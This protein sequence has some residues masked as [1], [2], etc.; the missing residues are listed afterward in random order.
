SPAAT[1][2][3]AADGDTGR[4]PVIAVAALATV[5]I[6]A[7]QNNIDMDVS[8]R[9]RRRVMR[10]RRAFEKAA[11]TGIS[12]AHSKV[13]AP[14]RTTITTPAKPTTM[15]IQRAGP[16][17]SASIGAEKAAIRV[18]LATMMVMTAASGSRL[19]A[20][21]RT[22]APTT[23]SAPRVSCPDHETIRKARQP[24]MSI[25]YGTMNSSVA[26]CRRQITCPTGNDSVKNLE[27]AS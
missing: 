10:S 16:T 18:G 11:A 7:D 13:V 21:T 25:T 19:N 4:H 17:R 15:A 26:A 14:G 24:L 3:A 22:A 20:L 2:H 23:N 5:T 1:S 9:T 27:T 6:N 12:S 8:V